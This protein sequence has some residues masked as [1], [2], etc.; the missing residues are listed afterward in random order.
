M[1]EDWDPSLRSAVMFGVWS[2]EF[3]RIRSRRVSPVRSAACN[4]HMIARSTCVQRRLQ[5]HTTH[6]RT[7]AHVQT[8]QFLDSC[9][10]DTPHP[11][12]SGS[13]FSRQVPNVS[14]VCQLQFTLFH[15]DRSR[16]AHSY[17]ALQVD[18]CGS[19]A[20]HV[21]VEPGD[22]HSIQL[23]TECCCNDLAWCG[24]DSGEQNGL[25][26]VFKCTPEYTLNN[27]QETF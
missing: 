11:L 10:K 26:C 18:W 12:C 5:T 6:R 17:S 24:D 2:L 19:N 14:R 15:S 21:V 7:H 23:Q 8:F 16:S 1:C 3:G 27:R 22:Q 13:I 9:S 25:E 20:L 4:A